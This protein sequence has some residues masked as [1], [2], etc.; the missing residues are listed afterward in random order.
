M[1][2]PLP[3]DWTFQHVLLRTTFRQCSC[4]ESHRGVDL[5]NAYTSTT[6]ILN[7][8]TAATQLIPIRERTIPADVEVVQ[9]FE[10]IPIAVCPA[11]ISSRPQPVKLPPLSADEWR[12]VVESKHREAQREKQAK[13]KPPTPAELSLA[14][15]SGDF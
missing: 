5:F 4:G 1:T 8:L 12:R 2:T 3:R 6:R 15:L 9:T 10:T 14:D 11:C 13:E 7:R